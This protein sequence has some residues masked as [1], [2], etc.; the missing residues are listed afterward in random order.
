MSIV[1]P[2]ERET[3]TRLTTA[4]ATVSWRQTS[5]LPELVIDGRLSQSIA[6]NFRTDSGIQALVEAFRL[7]HPPDNKKI[8]K[9]LGLQA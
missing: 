5:S 6:V 2:G 8:G 4:A 1:P 9:M 3:R 7:S